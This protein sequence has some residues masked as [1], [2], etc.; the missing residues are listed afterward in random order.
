MVDSSVFTTCLSLAMFGMGMLTLSYL[1]FRSA[2][3]LVRSTRQ[4]KL[5]A[6]AEAARINRRWQVLDRMRRK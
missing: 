4:E 5:Q 3:S 6:K 2:Q 1:Y